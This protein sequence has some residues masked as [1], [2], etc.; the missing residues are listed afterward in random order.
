MEIH[1]PEIQKARKT[2]AQ[3]ST[4]FLG[5]GLQSTRAIITI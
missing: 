5:S 1:V 4:R 2:P 3:A